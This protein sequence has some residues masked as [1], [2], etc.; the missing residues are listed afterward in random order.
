M[1]PT[2]YDPIEMDSSLYFEGELIS[3][4]ARQLTLLQRVFDTRSRCTQRISISRV[5]PITDVISS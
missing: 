3:T 2:F 4:H 1:M 5:G